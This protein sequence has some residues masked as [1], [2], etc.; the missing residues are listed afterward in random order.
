MHQT[1]EWRVVEFFFWGGIINI[2]IFV[3][4]VHRHH[5]K[6]LQGSLLTNQDFHGML[7]LVGSDHCSFSQ[8]SKAQNLK[9]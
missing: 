1:V 9:V 8:S 5:N 7:S 4:Q 3:A 6:P 2:I